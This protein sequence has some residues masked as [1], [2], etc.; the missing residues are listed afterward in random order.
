MLTEEELLKE[1]AEND[2]ELK[3]ARGQVSL[4]KEKLQDAETVL[5]GLKL[6]NDRMQER[7]RQRRLS[8]IQ[9]DEN[10]QAYEE[11]LERFR[12]KLPELMERL[13]KKSK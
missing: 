11:D 10:K 4:L 13:E 3:Q 1:I 5:I 12:Q 7:L 2:Y 6:K 8:T 9:P